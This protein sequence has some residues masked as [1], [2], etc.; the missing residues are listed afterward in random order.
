MGQGSMSRVAVESLRPEPGSQHQ[1]VMETTHE[2]L[3]ILR[4]CITTLFFRVFKDFIH[5]TLVHI[6]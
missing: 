3:G 2:F 4:L 1:H 6:H 5:T